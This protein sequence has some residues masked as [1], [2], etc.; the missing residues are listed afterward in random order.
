MRLT[1]PITSGRGSTS[2]GPSITVDGRGPTAPLAAA[3]DDL[4]RPGR[5]GSAGAVP[6]GAWGAEPGF[7]DGLGM[8][9]RPVLTQSARLKARKARILWG[10]E[11]GRRSDPRRPPTT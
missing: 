6:A 9:V 4:R 1:H 3:G 10:N 5:L 11:S 8:K 7:D 2:E